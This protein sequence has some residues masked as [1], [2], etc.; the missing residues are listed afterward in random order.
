MGEFFL[1]RRKTETQINAHKK[2]AVATPN[3]SPGLSVLEIFTETINIAN[4][5]EK[6]NNEYFFTEL[7]G[8]L[9]LFAIITFTLNC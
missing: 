8:V 6:P 4:I 9:E 2:G 1:K 5:N 3:N 7:R